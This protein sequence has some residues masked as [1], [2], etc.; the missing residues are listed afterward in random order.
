MQDGERAHTPHAAL[1]LAVLEQAPVII[2]LLGLDG[3]IQHVNPFFE[4]LTGWRLVDACGRD[5]FSSF[6]PERD[7]ERI[8]AL[9]LN[10]EGAAPARGSV[11]TCEEP[12]I[13]L[14]EQVRDDTCILWVRDNGIGFDMKLHDVMFELFQRF[15]SSDDYPGTGVGLA[16]VRKAAERMGGRVWAQS[17]PGRGATFYLEVPQ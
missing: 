16:I 11:S 5:W 15:H 1:P 12:S 2:L 14:G 13:E 7:R 17:E 8:R 4:E 3:R 6:L 9:F 10:A